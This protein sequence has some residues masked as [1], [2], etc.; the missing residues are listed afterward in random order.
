MDGKRSVS[1]CDCEGFEMILGFSVWMEI[2][3]LWI[4]VLFVADDVLLG[5]SLEALWKTGVN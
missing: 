5:L 3:I 1:L 4:W 2:G